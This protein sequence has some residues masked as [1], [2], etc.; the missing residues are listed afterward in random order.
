MQ[1]LAKRASGGGGAF[2][3]PKYNLSEVLDT[4]KWFC[5]A[6]VSTLAALA[7]C[8][9]SSQTSRIVVGE[10][11]AHNK[12]YHFWN[13]TEVQHALRM[14]ALAAMVYFQRHLKDNPNLTLND[15]GEEGVNGGWV[16]N[17]N[18]IEALF[19]HVAVSIDNIG[20]TLLLWFP[21]VSWKERLGK[22]ISLFFKGS[23]DIRFEGDA[24]EALELARGVEAHLKVLE[25][26]KRISQIQQWRDYDNLNTPRSGGLSLAA[27]RVRVDEKGNSAESVDEKDNSVERDGE[28]KTRKRVRVDKEG[29]SINSGDGEMKAW[30]VLLGPDDPFAIRTDARHM[31]GLALYCY[32]RGWDKIIS[33]YKNSSEGLNTP[34][35]I[36]SLASK[37]TGLNNESLRHARRK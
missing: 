1:G 3:E 10:E 12:K 2:S 37:D 36:T 21:Y 9:F 18:R 6:P 22:I 23:E 16:F 11:A 20:T 31:A 32:K 27:K 35:R 19:A 24:V 30:T 26:S 14:D 33:D 7:V 17:H 8:V 29:K 34:E 28:I 4:H 15:D 13:Y 25:D 5:D